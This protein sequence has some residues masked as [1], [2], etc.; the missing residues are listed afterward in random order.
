MESFLYLKPERL[1]DRNSGE[2]ISDALTLAAKA[3]TARAAVSALVG[4]V[5][6]GIAVASVILTA[7]CPE[8][9]Q[10]KSVFHEAR[11]IASWFTS[12][13]QPSGRS[14]SRRSTHPTD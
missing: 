6:I 5:G 1:I 13:R 11:Q 4:L 7:F 3:R 9:S 8:K 2:Y 14:V 10:R 12:S